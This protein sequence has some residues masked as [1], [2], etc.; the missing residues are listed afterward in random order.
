VEM[1]NGDCPYLAR[2]LWCSNS[3]MRDVSFTLAVRDSYRYGTITAERKRRPF[4]VGIRV[5]PKFA[6]IYRC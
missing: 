2:A 3:K 4:W 5:I 6:E 1:T